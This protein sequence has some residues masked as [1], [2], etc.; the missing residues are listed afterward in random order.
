MASTHSPHLTRLTCGTRAGQGC[1]PVQLQVRHPRSRSP[2]RATQS[3]ARTNDLEVDR[4]GA[5]MEAERKQRNSMFHTLAS[6][7]SRPRCERP[8]FPRYVEI[9][10][11]DMSVDGDLH[12]ERLRPFIRGCP[13][14]SPGEHSGCW[15]W[16]QTITVIWGGTGTELLLFRRLRPRRSRGRRG[17]SSER[18]FSRQQARLV[19]SRDAPPRSVRLQV[20]RLLEEWPRPRVVRRLPT[21]RPARLTRPFSAFSGHQ[22][23]RADFGGSLARQP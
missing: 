15:S 23:D 6:S 14:L 11:G 18:V 3:E 20:A 12:S 19:E 10:S 13:G 5:R 16:P 22:V 21:H 7:A 8:D 2:G 9:L 17:H 1:S 4:C